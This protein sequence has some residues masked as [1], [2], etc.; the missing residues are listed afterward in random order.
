MGLIKQLVDEPGA[1][2]PDDYARRV[3]GLAVLYPLVTVG[4][5][6]GEVLL[7]A[8]VKTLVTLAQRTNVETLVL[9]FFA[10]FFAYVG[11]LGVRGAPGGLRI[12]AWRLL[13]RARG[14]HEVER[15]KHA[16][17]P[18]AKDKGPFVALNVVVERSD[19]PGES[20]SLR[21]GDEAGTM[22]KLEIDGARVRHVP[23]KRDGSSNLLAYFAHQVGEVAGERQG[24]DVDVVAWGTLDD[25]E[26]HQFLSLVDF[27]RNLGE[28]LKTPGLWPRV[29]LSDPD[30]AE[31]ERR[32]SAVCPALREEALLPHWEY[33]AE[34]K[35]PIV[36]EPLGLASLGRTEKRADPL[37]ALSSLTVVV[38]VAVALLAA[39]VAAP[40]WI[41]GK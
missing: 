29:A 39:V 1:R 40:P 24:R 3:L 37:P 2:S 23:E 15:S 4:A 13:A 33:Q 30:C 31:L 22:G 18:A 10:V 32:L 21:V 6:A 38:L 27:A 20:F 35:L 17:L 28:A 14:R 25:E 41:P 9:A 8:R 5:A 16:R 26:A 7:V 34:H 19:R 11:T 36:P 12:L